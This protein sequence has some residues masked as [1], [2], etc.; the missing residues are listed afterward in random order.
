MSAAALF[1]PVVAFA[2][3]PKYVAGTSYFNPAVMGQSV[4][5][6]GGQV[7]YYVDQGALS[8]S[9]TNQQATAMVDSAAA[10]WSAVS[11]AG[12]TLTDKGSLDEDVNG[13]DIAVTNGQITAPADVTPAATSYPVG[14]MYDAD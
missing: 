10:L 2:G 9:V 11:T 6:P 4:R 3:G 13:A 12:V 1:V 5:W 7:G 8:D 14:V